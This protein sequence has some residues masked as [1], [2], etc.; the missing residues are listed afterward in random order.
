LRVADALKVNFGEV[1]F[2]AIKKVD[3]QQA[4]GMPNNPN[5]RK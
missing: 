5:V 1:L 4:S 3:G 2:M